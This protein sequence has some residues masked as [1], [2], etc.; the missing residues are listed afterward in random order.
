MMGVRIARRRK[1]K[2]KGEDIHREHSYILVHRCLG[3]GGGRAR[4]RGQDRQAWGERRQRGV[5]ETGTTLR[6]RWESFRFPDTASPLKIGCLNWIGKTINVSR[7]TVNSESRF[8]YQLYGET[9]NT[10]RF[11]YSQFRQSIFIIICRMR[12]AASR[13]FSV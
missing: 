12:E 9:R 4:R 3:G 8:T 2:D 10:S 5:L 6:K 11:P 1:D 13:C 7:L